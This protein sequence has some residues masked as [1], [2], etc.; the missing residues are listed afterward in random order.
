MILIET[1]NSR[2]SVSK[3]I[4]RSAFDKVGAVAILSCLGPFALAAVPFV[5]AETRQNPIFRQVRVGQYGQEFTIYK[6]RS[7]TG[8]KIGPVGRVIRKTKLDEVP[9]L[10]F[11]ILINRDMSLVGPRPHVPEEDIS[12]DP[13]RSTLKPGVT[14]YGKIIGG[15]SRSHAEELYADRVYIEACSQANMMQFILLNASLL[16]KTPAAIIA[17]RRSPISYQHRP[18]DPSPE[19]ALRF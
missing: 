11:N 17:Q 10:L 18:Q 9:Q 12:R 13:F 16:L 4:C 3:S 2:E 5:I 15:N 6:L 14:G 19:S 8:E 7:Y 1:K